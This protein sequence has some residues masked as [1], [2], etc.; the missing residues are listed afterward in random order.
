[1]TTM[2]DP[3]A[4]NESL[5]SSLL[6]RVR[7]EEEG[8][9]HRLV[10][11]YGPLVVRWCRKAGLSEQDAE[12]T[13]QDVFRAVAE[14]IHSFRRDKSSDTFR[15]WVCRITRFKVCD[16]Y[17]RREREVLAAGGTDANLALNQTPEMKFDAA[18]EPTEQDDLTEV[19]QRALALIQPAFKQN[20]WMA[21]W[22]VTVEGRPTA[23]VAEELGMSVGGVHVAKSRVLKR[24]REDMSDLEEVPNY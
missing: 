1:M 20:T 24:L 19:M 17:R 21:F 7:A 10:R 2:A 13:S 3:S 4:R 15:G 9:W 11:L 16:F 14:G 5:S 12:D 18:V 8:A 22:K 23:D 6:A